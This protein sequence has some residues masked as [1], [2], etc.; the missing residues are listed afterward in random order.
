MS[1]DLI[2][3]SKL[4]EDLN[5]NKIPFNEPINIIIKNQPA[6]NQWIDVNDRLPKEDSKEVLICFPWG[7]V[8]IGWRFNGHWTCECYNCDDS[9]VIAWMPLPEPYKK[10]VE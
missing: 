7:T 8:G 5:N 3:K 4:F 2:S 6:V 10:E 9:D 1:N